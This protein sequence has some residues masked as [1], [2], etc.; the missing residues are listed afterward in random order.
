M[1]TFVYRSVS[2]IVGTEALFLSKYKVP[3]QPQ[4]G[5]NMLES[6]RVGRLLGSLGPL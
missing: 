4:V 3:R 2:T 5:A 6:R 1:M